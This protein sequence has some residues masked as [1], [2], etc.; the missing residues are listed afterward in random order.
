[1]T[2]ADCVYGWIDDGTGQPV[3][4]D[5]K[6][7][8]GYNPS[9]ID[10]QQDYVAVSG[11]F[12]NGLALTGSSAPVVAACRCAGVY[13]PWRRRDTRVSFRRALD[14]GDADDM[15][16]TAGPTNVI[17]AIHSSK[18]R[19]AD[20]FLATHSVRERGAVLVDLM[21]SPGVKL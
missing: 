4:T 9:T 6:N 10:S 20:G 15:A 12:S 13:R 8:V 21:C 18:P 1:M 7:K 3:L 19:R 17:W 16:L 14:T 5:R 11:S 2:P